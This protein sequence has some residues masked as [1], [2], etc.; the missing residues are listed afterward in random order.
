[1]CLV[2]YIKCLKYSRLTGPNAFYFIDFDE[3]LDQQFHD[4]SENAQCFNLRGTYTCSCKEGFADLSENPTYSG[5]VCSAEQLG[6]AKCHYHGTCYSR[7]MEDVHCECFQW[8]TG[9]NCHLNLKCMYFNK[10]L[11]FPIPLINILNLVLL[12]GLVTLG[13]ILFTLLLF[14]IMMTCVKKRNRNNRNRPMTVSILPHSSHHSTSSKK[15]DKKAMIL[16]TSSETSEES[17]NLPYVN[18]V[19]FF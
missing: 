12:I 4:C 2:S 14:C 6:C 15:I 5:R 3:C 1:M 16:D 18:K 7:N 10:L 17:T 9:A 19:H 11:Y 13:A 8:Y